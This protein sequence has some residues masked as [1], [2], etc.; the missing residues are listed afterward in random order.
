[1]AGGL[2]VVNRVEPLRRI[3]WRISIEDNCR[4]VANLCAGRQTLLL[5]NKEG[6]AALSCRWTNI[7]RQKSGQRILRVCAGRRIER[8]ETPG[9]QS[10]SIESSVDSHNKILFRPQVYVSDVIT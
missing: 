5:S 7:W 10:G 4:L 8:S 6:D 1:M 2:R 9:E 3:N